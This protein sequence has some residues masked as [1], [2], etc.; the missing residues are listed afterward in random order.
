MKEKSGLDLYFCHTCCS[1]SGISNWQGPHHVAQKFTTTTL[2]AWS[3]S[4]KA[5]PEAWS[6]EKA[7]IL[8]P[9]FVCVLN[10]ESASVRAQTG[11]TKSSTDKIRRP[12]RRIV[13]ARSRADCEGNSG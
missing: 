1:S 3:A 7:G 10:S 8:S 2:P 6:T 12:P 13:R 5:L 9:T 4:E 11:K